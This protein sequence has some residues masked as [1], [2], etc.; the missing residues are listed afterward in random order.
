MIHQAVAQSVETWLGNW[1][2]VGSS[3]AIGGGD[4]DV[5]LYLG[6]LFDVIIIPLIARLAWAPHCCLQLYLLLFPLSSAMGCLWQP[7]EP[8]VKKL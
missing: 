5:S 2:V 4:F 6:K 7:I 3:P 1:R 8:Y